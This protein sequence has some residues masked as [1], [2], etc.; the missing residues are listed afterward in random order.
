MYEKINIRLE[1]DK[2]I[3]ALGL[4]LFGEEHKSAIN[5]FV[6]TLKVMQYVPDGDW[7]HDFNHWA[8]VA[9]RAD[10]FAEDMGLSLL[11]RQT[12]YVAAL[13]HDANHSL[14]KESDVQNITVAM[15][16]YQCNAY[17]LENNFMSHISVEEVCNA[18][19]CTIFPFKIRPTTNVECCLRDADL[20][21]SF[22]PDAEDFAKGLQHEFA[23]KGIQEE[24]TPQTMHDF[25]KG[26]RFYTLPCAKLFNQPYCYRFKK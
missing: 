4:H 18:I 22:E 19:L 7:Y 15:F 12:L 24:V 20:C 6:T 3:I 25:A 26:Q 14:G 5:H 1:R 11:E 8:A 2:Q 10:Q 16:T 9:L 13:F 23:V 21:M 17:L